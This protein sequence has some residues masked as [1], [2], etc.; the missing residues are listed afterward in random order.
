M[1]V[2]LRKGTQG[3]L[4]RWLWVPKQYISVDA[5]KSALTHVLSDSYTGQ[6]RFL[7]LWRESHDHLLVPRAFWDPMRLPF[8]VVD[9]RPQNYPHI[10][11]QHSILL[12]H[13]PELVDGQVTLISTG[14]DVQRRSVKALYDA[15]GGV[16]Q[17]ACGRG[18]TVI[19][20]YKIATGEV[21]ALV[22]CDN[23]NLLYQWRKE[24][25]KM[26]YVPGGIGFFGDGKR[27]WKKGLVLATYH[28]I[29][30]WADT[31][32]EEA[33][34]WFGQIF[35]DEGHHISAPT[36]A[37]TAAMFYGSRYSL[38]AT[39]ERD[40]GLHVIADV[41]VGKVLFKDLSPTLTPRFA[42]YWSGLELNLSDPIV[43]TMCLDINQE[44]HLSKVQTFFGQWTQRLQLIIDLVNEAGNNGRCILV[45]SNSVD[46]VVN[47]MAMYELG[48]T[49]GQLYTDIPIPTPAEF[50]ET[51][52][53]IDLTKKEQ[54]KLA[55]KKEKL[56]RQKRNPK[57]T[58]ADLVQFDAEL[59]QVD[60]AFKQFEIHKKIQ[61]ELKK[62]QRQYVKNLVAR[63][64]QTGLLTYD[65]PAKTRQEMLGS[66]NIIFAVTKYGKEGMDCPRLDTVILSSLFSSR[67]GLQ[68]LLGRPTRP[69]PGKK[70]PTLVAVVDN[71][72]QCI[73]MSKKLAQHLRDW[74]N[75]EGGPFQPLYI[76]YPQTWTKNSRT[77]NIQ[78][79]LGP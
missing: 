51:L 16:L 10:P 21:P 15:P 69:L 20:L 53:P 26:L 37:T 5:T 55:K 76:G 27:E 67:N 61:N 47:L 56:E 60:Q 34:R 74:P 42:F 40:D 50:G 31:I 4:D 52:T 72:G 38:T 66:K 25:E 62:R 70:T 35:W 41:H 14:L 7:Y 48:A 2:I 1:K 30:N 45:L 3:Y 58:P 24:A 36:F 79:L 12:D 11:F 71:V 23:I 44:V 64:Q 29:A 33:R 19:A 54:A 68:Q 22:M 28:S 8:P 59:T 6:E 75:D 9:C 32:P 73:G 46:E 13:R 63:A 65:V 18:K 17:L 78:T 77:T 43:R 49:A 39:P 57:A